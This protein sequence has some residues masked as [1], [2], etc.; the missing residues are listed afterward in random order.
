MRIVKAK[1]PHVT[2]TRRS[3]NKTIKIERRDNSTL[4]KKQETLSLLRDKFRLSVAQGKPVNNLLSEIYRLGCEL[5]AAG[6]A[7]RQ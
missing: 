2:S 7:V 4:R 1:A 6:K 3:F 5:E